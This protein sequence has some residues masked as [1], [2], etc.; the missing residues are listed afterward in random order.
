MRANLGLCAPGEWVGSGRLFVLM[1]QQLLLLMLHIATVSQ[2][3]KS[4]NQG[5]ELSLGVIYG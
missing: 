3:Q 1:L 2:P 5:E 4:E